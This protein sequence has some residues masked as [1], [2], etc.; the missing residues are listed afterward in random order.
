MEQ[1]QDFECVPAVVWIPPNTEYI[2]LSIAIRTDS[3]ILRPL[4]RTLSPEET[5]EAI[6]DADR[7]YC[8]EEYG[9]TYVAR[10]ARREYLNG[11][12]ENIGKDD[13]N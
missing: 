4:K 9:Y 5:K 12:T 13:N 7:N 8:N 2:N 6:E 1:T 3:G 10:D 11:V